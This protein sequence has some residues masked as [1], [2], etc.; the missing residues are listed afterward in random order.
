ME[1]MKIQEKHGNIHSNDIND[2]LKSLKNDIFT[3][4]KCMLSGILVFKSID[5][6]LVVTCSA[7]LT[8]FY[9]GQLITCIFNSYSCLFYVIV[10]YVIIVFMNFLHWYAILLKSILMY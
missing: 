1:L 4:I 6:T 5:K 7:I 3:D 8:L 9:S 2:A 10:M